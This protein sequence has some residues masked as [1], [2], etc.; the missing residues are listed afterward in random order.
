MKYILYTIIFISLLIGCGEKDKETAIKEQKD[1]YAFDTTDIK[2]VP[3]K[4]TNQDY[5]LNYNLEKNKTY[6]YRISVLST[7]KQKFIVPDTTLSQTLNQTSVYLAGFN[8]E[9]I[10]KDSTLEIGCNI[11]SIKLNIS[12]DQN[13]ASYESGVTPDSLIKQNF[14]EYDALINNEFSIRISKYGEI[15]EIFRVDNIVNKY[16]NTKGIADSVSATQKDQ[17]RMGI[18]EGLLKPLV[19]QVFRQFPKKPVA[20]DSTWSFSQPPTSIIIFQSQNTTTYKLTNLEK[21]GDEKLAIIKAG[22]ITKITGKN[23]MTDKGIVYEFKKPVTDASGKIYFNLSRGV[24]QKSKTSLKI[25]LSF[26][27][28]TQTP[29]GKQKGNR[30]EETNTTNVVELL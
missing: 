25:H 16:L 13:S 30:E 9:N 3:V 27:M 18:I 26:S 24:I 15:S 6:N 5:R 22:L 20:V 2:T 21:T 23:T 4:E 10:D 7:N 19:I 12:S 1:K 14:A 8:L 29:K 28:E 11:S 17:M